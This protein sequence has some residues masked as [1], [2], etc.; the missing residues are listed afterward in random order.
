MCHQGVDDER[1]WVEVDIGRRPDEG[2]D[3][4]VPSYV[5]IS[6]AAGFQAAIRTDTINHVMQ[7]T[8]EMNS[9]PDLL[10][11]DFYFRDSSKTMYFRRVSVPSVPASGGSSGSGGGGAAE[12]STSTTAPEKPDLK[13]KILQASGGAQSSFLGIPALKTLV[14]G[15]EASALD[16]M[17]MGT[18][19]RDGGM[20]TGE[21]LT[22]WL[23]QAQGGTL[24]TCI[25]E[26]KD[27]DSEAQLVYRR[28]TQHV[29]AFK[30]KDLKGKT[31][32]EILAIVDAQAVNESM[33]L[34]E[35]L[36][37]SLTAYATSGETRQSY[38]FTALP[39]IE[40]RLTGQA[41]ASLTSGE[42]TVGQ[43]IGAALLE[44]TEDIREA[45]N[46]QRQELQRARDRG[47]EDAMDVDAG[48]DEVDAFGSSDQA[49]QFEEFYHSQAL[50][51]SLYV[52]EQAS[53]MTKDGAT[54]AVVR[55]LC[56][57]EVY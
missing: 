51:Y 56:D 19:M 1:D 11:P 22:Q 48:R 32:E 29:V 6:C 15:T 4:K 8:K 40:A 54:F 33:L 12:A 39:M 10:M 17:V 14:E 16:L 9:H 31:R 7:Y 50:R 13:V 37:D 42:S 23:Q 46:E 3:V 26:S 30:P 35:K 49:E 25:I 45:V 44:K 27:E 38:T 5:C 21:N 20:L 43:Q 47:K 53:K 41:A 24:Q 34:R 28:Q 2:Q 36:A 18:H 55:R 57:Q 52:R